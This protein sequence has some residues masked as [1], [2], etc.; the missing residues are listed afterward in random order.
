MA[1][2]ARNECSNHR[3]A[4]LGRLDLEIRLD[5]AVKGHAADQIKT[6]RAINQHTAPIGVQL[7][8]VSLWNI[9]S[10]RYKQPWL[11]AE[12]TSSIC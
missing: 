1:N 11:I 5:L 8:A 2:T 7:S 12:D 9:P 3:G 4:V 10:S 6:H